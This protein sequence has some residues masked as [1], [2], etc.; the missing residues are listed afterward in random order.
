VKTSGQCMVIASTGLGQ[1][2][3]IGLCSGPTDAEEP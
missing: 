1:E 2:R 3:D